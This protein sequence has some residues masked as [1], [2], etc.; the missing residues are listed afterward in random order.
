M[1]VFCQPCRRHQ[2]WIITFLLYILRKVSWF[3]ND[4]FFF[5]FALVVSLLLG[6]KEDSDYFTWHIY[7]FLTEN[8]TQIVLLLSR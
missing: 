3:N 6:Q 2:Y 1:Y 8:R 4:T 7:F 5:F